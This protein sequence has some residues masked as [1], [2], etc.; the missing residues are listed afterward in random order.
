M[1]VN[2]IFERWRE[3]LKKHPK[4]ERSQKRPMDKY[5]ANQPILPNNMMISRGIYSQGGPCDRSVAT[6]LE[7]RLSLIHSTFAGSKKRSCVKS[8]PIYI[9][10]G[11]VNPHHSYDGEAPQTLTIPMI[12]SLLEAQK[13]TSCII[14]ENALQAS[15]F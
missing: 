6:I 15:I 3:T 1:S 5:H 4:M 12:A 13:I 7:R 11:C 10:G 9:S 14:L 8:Q 2:V